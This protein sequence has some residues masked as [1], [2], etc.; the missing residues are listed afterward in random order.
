MV[1]SFPTFAAGSIG[2]TGVADGKI[3]RFTVTANANGG[4]GLNQFKF[5][6]ATTS[7]TVTNINMFGYTDSGYSAAVSG[8]T[9]GQISASNVSPTATAFTITPS[10]VINIPAGTTYY[11]E[12][13]GTVTASA[14][15]Y[16]VTTTLNGDSVYYPAINTYVAGGANMA[17][18]SAI[19]VTAGANLVWSPNA[20]TTSSATHS[21]WTSGYSVPGLPSS[22]LIQTRSN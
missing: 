11:F 12:V 3:M 18:T 15:T 17:S 16:S 13:R 2:T 22:G 7:A 20:T 14:T 1:K 6:I 21:D 9:S 8:F 4:V 5:A 19:V 10:A